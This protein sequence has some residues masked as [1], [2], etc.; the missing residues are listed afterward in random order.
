M[1]NMVEEPEILFLGRNCRKL[2]KNSWLCNYS[3]RSVENETQD[4][5]NGEH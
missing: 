5:P 3:Q 4:L 2:K 1:Y